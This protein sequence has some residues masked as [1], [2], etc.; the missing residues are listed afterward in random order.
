[1]DVRRSKGVANCD[2][3]VKTSTSGQSIRFQNGGDV[4]PGQSLLEYQVQFCMVHKTTNI[5]A[6]RKAIEACGVE[7]PVTRRDQIHA[8]VSSHFEGNG[9]TKFV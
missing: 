8:Y 3:P 2:I 7:E 9:D 6:V 5:Q 1:M 4:R